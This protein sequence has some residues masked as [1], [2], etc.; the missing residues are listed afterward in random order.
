[1][2]DFHQIYGWTTTAYIYTENIKHVLQCFTYTLEIFGWIFVWNI[3]KNNIIFSFRSLVYS[4][5]LAK[6]APA[7]KLK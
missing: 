1:M 7:E 2:V 6:K 4:E 3:F 5:L